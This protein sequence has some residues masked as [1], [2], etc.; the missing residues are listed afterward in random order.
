M[1]SN[2]T[3]LLQARVMPEVHAAVTKLADK[4]GVPAAT[5]LRWAIAEYIEKE[6]ADENR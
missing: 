4:C 2:R 6:A 3:R 5:I 1:K